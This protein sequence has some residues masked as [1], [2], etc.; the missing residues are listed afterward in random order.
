MSGDALLVISVFGGAMAGMTSFALAM[1]RH[2][3][4]LYGQPLPIGT[5]RLLRLAGAASLLAIAW[6]C[7]AGWGLSIGAVVWAGSVCL[8]ALA[9]TA[10]LTWWPRVVP[11][12]G[13]A[14]AVFGLIG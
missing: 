10:A 1:A 13:T 5:A 7:A 11:L 14:A 6:P 8:A 9:V 3:E 12:A 2:F 4:R